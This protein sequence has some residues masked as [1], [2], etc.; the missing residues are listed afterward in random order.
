MHANDIYST[1]R[2]P[3]KPLFYVCASS[4]T[5]HKAAPSGCENLFFLVPLASGIDSDDTDMREKCFEGIVKRMEVHTGQKLSNAI[6]FKRSFA[7]SDFINEY[8]SFKGNAYGLANT[9]TQ[10]AIFKP[11]CKSKK[12]KNL[13][14]AG[15]LTVPG[16]GVPPAIISGEVAAK[17]ALKNFGLS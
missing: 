15:Q 14:Y 12:V 9:L 7:Q 8:N 5:D 6:V 2:W 3:Q 4:V 11:A 1:K 17:Q 13:F 10:T 16:P